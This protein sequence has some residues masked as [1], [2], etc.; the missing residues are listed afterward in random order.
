MSEMAKAVG[1]DEDAAAFLA[2]AELARETFQ[3][4]LFDD[5]AGIYRDGIGT[6]HSSIHANFFPLAFDL[7]PEDKK[8]GVLKWLQ[9]KDMQ[10]SVYAAQYF[11]ES[12]FNNGSDEKAIDLITAD[13]DRSW[14]HMVNSGTTISWEAWG[15]KYK[16]NQDWNHAWG[17]APANLLPRFVLGA[18]TA[19][20][21]WGTAVIRPCPAGLKFARGKVPTPLGPVSIDWKNESSFQLQLALPDGMKARIE[22]PATE[23]SSRVLANGEPVQATRQGDR[24]VVTDPVDGSVEYE[25]E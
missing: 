4:T 11:M 10:C 16:A 9:Q 8:E 20:P 1:K 12:L 6:D 3:K 24:W 18:Q 17:A 22:L 14:K 5:K 13:G 25:V 7:V 15:M 21:G 23:G 2:R 19:S